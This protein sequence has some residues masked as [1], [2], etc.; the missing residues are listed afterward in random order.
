[1]PDC[2]ISIDALSE[3][4]HLLLHSISFHE[5]IA[6]FYEIS[7]EIPPRHCGSAINGRHFKVPIS[8]L[9]ENI[10]RFSDLP[11]IHFVW[12]TDFC[13]STLYANALHSMNGLYLYNETQLFCSLAM[14]KRQIDSGQLKLNHEV[15]QMVLRI[16]LFFQARTFHPG[17]IAVVKEWPLSN[18]LIKEILR[19]APHSRGVF[20][21]TSLQEYLVA[22][23]K[24]QER[25]QQVLDRVTQHFIEIHSI[26]VLKNI[27]LGNLS[28]AE[29]AALQWLNLMYL[30][31]DHEY[32]KENQ[33]RTLHNE[34][35]FSRTA[36][37]L[38]ATAQHFELE[39]SPQAINRIVNGPVFKQH[40]KDQNKAY[41]RQQQEASIKQALDKYGCEVEQG[42]EW[43]QTFLDAYPLPEHP[44]IALLGDL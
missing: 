14:A 39:V 18:I 43:A 28:D 12:M 11:T 37:V 6:N 1:M 35:F 44:A 15:W 32:K 2:P 23:L 27:D 3:N 8:T 7:E 4:P 5:E 20:M 24:S 13:G 26:Q 10:E 22:C 34:F 40:S 21:Y 16:A 38:A 42:L 9:L 31:N 41:S 30:H 25:R 36:D 29:A 33:L 19:T 17:D